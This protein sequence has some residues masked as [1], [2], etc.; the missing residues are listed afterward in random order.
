MR[1]KVYTQTFVEGLQTTGLEDGLRLPRF[2]TFQNVRTDQG[3]AKR[4]RGIQRVTGASDPSTALDLDSGSSH[5][6]LIP[7]GTAWAAM[8]KRWTLE[9]LVQPSGVSGTQY[10]LGASGASPPVE[11]YLDDDVVTA[12]VLDSDSASTTLT[13]SAVT[14]ERLAIQ[15]VRD[16]T[17]LTLRVN[18]AVEDTDT[19]ADKDCKTTGANMFLGR[20]SGGGY[21][22]GVYDFARA[23]AVAL[24]DQRDGMLR[25]HD[26]RVRGYVLWDYVCE[27]AEATTK[28]VNDRGPFGNHGGF[29]G[30]PATASALS[31]QVTP[32]GLIKDY[33]DYQNRRRL[34]VIAG[35]EIHLAEIGV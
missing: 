14:A 8:G 30:T 12:V 20:D 1:R 22:D 16:G 7:N 34:A 9:F 18:G 4:R 25:L 35:S 27:I 32:V 5:H 31:H 11:I 10:I 26:P 28:R 19:M 6:I 2:S 15:L 21:F 24:P 33:V 29:V 23:L 13:S 3:A 17:S